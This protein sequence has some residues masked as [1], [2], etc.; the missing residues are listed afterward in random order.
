MQSGDTLFRIALN[1][2]VALDDLLTANNL[3]NA[4]IIQPEQVLL[5]PNCND[6]EPEVVET[7]EDLAGG[8][9]AEAAEDPVL[10]DLRRHRLGGH[11]GDGRNG[12]GGGG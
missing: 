1:N 4:S 6:E 2:D 5:I 11:R 3:S 8:A 12:N 9:I 7:E 10:A